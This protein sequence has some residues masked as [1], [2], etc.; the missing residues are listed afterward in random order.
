[1]DNVMFFKNKIQLECHTLCLCRLEVQ[2]EK[3]K[4]KLKKTRIDI[5]VEPGKSI[6]SK[7]VNFR[8]FQY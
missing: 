2:Q 6:M 3:E 5:D 7:N 4:K 8:Q 1:M